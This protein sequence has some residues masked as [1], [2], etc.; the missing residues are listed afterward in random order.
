MT[1]ETELKDTQ[2]GYADAWLGDADRDIM[3]LGVNVEDQRERFWFSYA[4]LRDAVVL[5][6]EGYPFPEVFSD[7]DPN[8]L[9]CNQRANVVIVYPH[10]NTT[11]PVALEQGAKLAQ[12][13]INLML[14]AFPYIEYDEKY[15]RQVLR[16]PDGF[17]YIGAD[18]Y[19]AALIASGVKPQEAEEKCGSKFLPL[20]RG[21][22]GDFLDDRGIL[23][24][25]KFKE[26]II[27]HGIFFHFTHSMRPEIGTVGAP[28]IQ[29]IIW[30]AATHLKCRL[31]DMLKGS[32]VRTADQ[33]NWYKHQTVR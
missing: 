2:P 22:R 7:L 4:R 23:V 18:D 28:L 1:T 33:I 32:G 26:S 25:V 27:A 29:P 10:G 8:V 5:R 14:C 17:M 16:V 3:G 30:E 6:H 21:D 15:G 9:K 11:V 13:G 12:E 24:A 19:E 31:P 20:K